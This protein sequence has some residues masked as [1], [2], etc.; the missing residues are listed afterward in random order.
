MSG[1]ATGLSLALFAFRAIGQSY[2]SLPRIGIN[3]NYM[4]FTFAALLSLSKEG[5]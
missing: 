1:N 4:M 5:V 3:D 2:L